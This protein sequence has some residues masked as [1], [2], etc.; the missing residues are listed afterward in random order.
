[1]GWTAL[2]YTVGDG[3]A[4]AVWGTYASDA[5]GRLG[6]CHRSTA[7]VAVLACENDVILS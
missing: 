3:T 7:P 6:F 1:M 4:V 2:L 5:I